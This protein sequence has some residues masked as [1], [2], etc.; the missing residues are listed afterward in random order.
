MRKSGGPKTF[1]ADFTFGVATSAYQ[2]EG[3]IEND[4]S[5][6][7]RAGKL[8]EPHVRCGRG[9]DHWNRYEEDLGLAKDIGC[10]AF[11]ISIEWARVEP[12][13]GKV[14][15]EAVRAYRRR[16]ELMKAAG[17]RPVVTLHH[18]TH[19]TWFHRETPWHL[20]S[21]VEAFRQYARVCADIL[22]GIGAMVVTF[23]EPVPLF[24]GGYMKGVIPPG[25]INY[26]QAMAAA[27]NLAR[28]HVA[29]REEIEKRAG[30]HQFGIA[31]NLMVFSPD[32]AWHPIDRALCRLS[33]QAYNHAFIE[34]VTQ[35][36]LK[37]S[38]PGLIST[39]QKIE[40]GKGS[41]DFVGVNYYTR[42]H[43]RFTRQ[44]PHVDFLFRDK[45]SRGL[46]HIGW[47]DYPEGFL[48][49]LLEMKR[50]QL[51]IWVTENGIDDRVGDRRP[52][53]LHTH[54]QAVLD[55]IAQGVDVKGYLYWSL[56]DNFEWLEGWG[57]RFGLYQ[58]D[59]DTLKRSPTAACEY[60]KQMVKTRTLVAPPEAEPGRSSGPAPGGGPI[61]AAG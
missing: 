37:I 58:V 24:L 6:W 5:E 56:M 43:L 50:Y 18:Y 47:E 48:Q 22:D 1:P 33:S 9:V 59:F 20:P 8:K 25:I 44:A 49:I 34:A 31:Q 57:P 12:V 46:T 26:P 3:H 60:F 11:R 15:H 17:I 16:L 7:E 51:P 42:A 55:A 54:W 2:V 36:E 28:A 61:L 38:F 21:S 52:K 53:F 35:G 45:F 30:K 13:R 39:K 23:N 4:W 27:A 19:P 10:E 41:S 40:G 14:D 29:A 32:R